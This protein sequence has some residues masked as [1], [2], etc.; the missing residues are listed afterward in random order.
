MCCVLT[1]NLLVFTQKWDAFLEINARGNTSEQWHQHLHPN[2]SILIISIYRFN[3]QSA[4]S[5]LT[6]T[7]NCL[8]HSSIASWP[9][10][11]LPP[12]ASLPL[13]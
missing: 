6:R 2:R 11:I 13:A 10:E 8:L 3:H 9:S 7:N 5:K 1:T 4:R 12:L